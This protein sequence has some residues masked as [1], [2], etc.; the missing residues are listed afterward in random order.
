[1]RMLVLAF[2]LALLTAPAFADAIQPSDAG[3]HVGQT[4]TVE[5][6]VG[7]VHT[8]RSGVT[9]IDMG[10]RYPNNSFTPVIFAKDASKFPDV[11]SLSGKTVDITGPVRLYKGKPEIIVKDAAQLKSQ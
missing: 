10:G 6:S 5:G 2:G 1:M 11:G 3:A 8:A 9:F 4:V 7:D